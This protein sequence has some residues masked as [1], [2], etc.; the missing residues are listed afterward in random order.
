MQEV[1]AI[2]ETKF[3]LNKAI[4]LRNVRKNININDHS[5]L[6]R[7]MNIEHVKD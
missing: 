2:L 4:H 6:S 3:T 7:S 1:Q 5:N